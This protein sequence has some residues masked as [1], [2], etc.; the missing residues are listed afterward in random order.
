M[1]ILPLSPTDSFSRH[2]Y[3]SINRRFKGYADLAPEFSRDSEQKG[4]CVIWVICGFKLE[5]QVRQILLVLAAQSPAVPQRPLRPQLEPDRH[6]Q[7][8]QRSPDDRE[9][10][11]VRQHQRH[12]RPSLARRA[13]R[14]L[15]GAAKFAAKRR[16]AVLT[17]T[18]RTVTA[19]AV[20][21]AVTTAKVVLAMTPLKILWSSGGATFSGVAKR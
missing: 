10:N 12:Q 8:Q 2:D 13:R 18:T 11:R 19:T 9:N 20:A 6:P 4:I 17:M 3:S 5:A 7:Q 1:S 15:S 21:A 16:K 14:L